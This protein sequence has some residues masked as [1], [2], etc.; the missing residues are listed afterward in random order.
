V[1]TDKHLLLFATMQ[2]GQFLG[3]EEARRRQRYAV[4]SGLQSAGYTPT[5]SGRLQLFKTP[6]S[7]LRSFAAGWPQMHSSE[8]EDWLRVPYEHWVLDELRTDGNQAVGRYSAIT[9]LW[10]DENRLPLPSKLDALTSL[11]GMAKVNLERRQRCDSSETGSCWPHVALLGPSNTDALRW[12]LRDLKVRER[13]EQDTALKRETVLKEEAAAKSGAV[14]FS[15]RTASPAPRASAT[16]PDGRSEPVEP[17]QAKYARDGY[18]MLAKGRVFNA[19]ST[20]QADFVPELKEAKT[21][22]WQA[23]CNGA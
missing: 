16:R 21:L 8:E 18:L 6:L 3:G 9:V 17:A 5:D 15:S 10:V 4:L 23:W 20:V 22:I 11:L 7:A 14:R 1:A 12:A 13:R 2:G 19:G